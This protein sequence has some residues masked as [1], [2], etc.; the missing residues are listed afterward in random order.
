VLLLLAAQVMQPY[1]F[2]LMFAATTSRPPRGEL[3]EI[4]RS[5]IAL[6]EKVSPSVV[7]CGTG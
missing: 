5:T 3:S 4:E 6:F 1:V 7:R 2:R